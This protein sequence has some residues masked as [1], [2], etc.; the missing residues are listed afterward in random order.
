MRI[1]TVLILALVL[2]ACGGEDNAGAADGVTEALKERADPAER[3]LVKIRDAVVKFYAEK[4]T[5][6]QSVSD[7]AG[8]GGGPDE[9]EV[10]DDYADI[11][12]TFTAQALKFDAQGKLT[13]GWFLA[14]PKGT[15][16]A[17]KVRMNGVTGEY[18][19]ILKNQDWTA[20][21]EDH[22]WA[23]GEQPNP[24]ENLTTE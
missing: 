14:S 3:N 18:E 10:S 12:F 15:S 22:G 2:A 21:E 19:Y 4:K 13:R 23:P 17:P 24:D 11:G 7:L 16:E 6:P 1:A 5:A 9:L 20:A 8:F